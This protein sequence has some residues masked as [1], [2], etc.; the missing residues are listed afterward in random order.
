[1]E[2]GFTPIEAAKKGVGEVALPIISS[3]ATTLAAFL[4]LA[5][6]PGIMGEFMKYLPITL[7]ITLGFLIICG[8]GHK[9]GVYF[10]IHENSGS[11]GDQQTQSQKGFHNYF[12]NWSTHCHPILFCGYTSGMVGKFADSAGNS[13]SAQCILANPFIRQVSVDRFAIFRKN[14]CWHFALCRN[15]KTTLF[16]FLGVPF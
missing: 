11:G 6:W 14:L 5:F 16:Y 7:I 1:M 8:S 3:T 13:D 4:P 15:K 2:E 10:Q 9:P 12:G